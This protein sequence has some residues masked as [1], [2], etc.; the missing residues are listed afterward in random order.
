M[1]TPER[2]REARSASLIFHA[3]L[4]RFGIDTVD[5]TLDSWQEVT[6]TPNQVQSTAVRWLQRIIDV[7]LGRRSRARDMAFA[8][9]RYH[10]ALHTG[11][12]LPPL[13]DEPEGLAAPLSALRDDFFSQVEDLSPG[14]LDEDGTLNDSDG[15]E[16]TGPPSTDEESVLLEEVEGLDDE[17]ADL[18]ERAEQEAEVGLFA[19]VLGL[20]RK[21]RELDDEQPAA[22]VDAEREEAFDQAGAQAAAAAERVALS[23]ARD[24][25]MAATRRDPR[26]IGYARVS[27]TGSP[28]GWCAMLISRGAVYR[29]AASATAASSKAANRS[30]GETFHP[31]CKCF[32]E[33]VYSQEQYDEDDRFDLNRELQA[34]W[35]QV[36]KRLKG[37]AA[38]NAWRTYIRNR[39]K[40]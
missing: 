40:A 33:P 12:T 32:G 35:P 1:T 10:R 7:V 25:L 29:S 11:Y 9:Y 20:Q 30:E 24:D 31:N 39:N 14:L 18:D 4:V 38:L 37:K 5:D 28:C 21:L 6:P 3:A 19:P 36:T 26:V 16:V 17:R 22:E 13:G 23:A 8:Y 2:R 34:L 27:G 15:V